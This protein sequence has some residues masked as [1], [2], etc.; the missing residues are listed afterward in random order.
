MT[1]IV[2]LDR[3]SIKATL[4]RPAFPHEW[5]EYPNS[6][7]VEALTRLQGAEIAITNKVPL[8]AETLAALP[9]LKKVAISATGTNGVDL[10]YCKARG[11]VVSNIQGYA[12]TTVPEHVLSMMLALSR[13][14]FAWRHTVAA[15]AW[16]ASPQ[17]CLFDHPIRDLHGA[18]LGLIGV[19]SLGQGV[20]KLA[21]AF[22]MTVWHAERKGAT[23]CRPGFV[24]F[25]TVLTQADI[26]SLHCPLTPETRDL[27]GETELQ[28]MKSSALLI[29]T[30]RGGI[31]NEPALAMAL[32]QGWIAGAAT[33]VLST[34]PPPADHPLLAPD[35]LAMPNFLVTPH[36]AWSS[37][38]AMQALADQLIDN[39]EA[40]MAGHPQ[41]QVA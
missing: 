30:A 16:Q 35:L 8:S 12:N 2:C 37:A 28:A 5:V 1:R 18:C 40:Y 15:G 41:H 36:V 21:E 27:I 24:P 7:A 25:D 22:G 29:N 39:I 26:L 9:Q 38:P 20:A 32:R 3:E 31:V 10:A 13:N 4:R 19:G 6:T 34:E 23:T 11:I 17:F 33:D 14:L